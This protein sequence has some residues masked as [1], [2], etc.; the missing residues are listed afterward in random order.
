M[1]IVVTGATGHLG[2]LIVEHLIARGTAPA[3]IVAVGRN[4]ARLAELPEGVRTAAIDLNDPDSLSE[5]FA[6]ADRLML[7][8]SSDPGAR[9]PQHRNA[10]EAAKVA[11]ITRI[12]YTSAPKATTSELILAPDHKATEEMLV[13]SGITF[14]VLRNNWYSENYVGPMAQAAESGSYSSST[15]DGLVASAS[16]TDYAEAAAVVL[17]T[18]GHDNSVYELTGDTAWSAPTLAAAFSEVVGRDI[19]FVPITTEQEAEGLT[20]AGLDE[21][22]VGFVT[23]LNRNIRDGALAEVTP[24]LRTLIG[25]PTTP[26]VEGLRAGR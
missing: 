19:E 2:R 11:G 20:A 21:A 6:G 7:V 17:T 5:P 18:D 4:Q 3:D 15:G 24:D 23:T 12:V 9:I 14:T 22:T 1:T 10:I 26:L 25:R 8:S 16:R 13:T